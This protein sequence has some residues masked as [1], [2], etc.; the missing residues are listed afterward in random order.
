MKYTFEL[1]RN[2]Q[3]YNHLLI[4]TYGEERYELICESAPCKEKTIIFWPESIG[5]SSERTERVIADLQK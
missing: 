1:I 2:I 4:C 5:L 3:M